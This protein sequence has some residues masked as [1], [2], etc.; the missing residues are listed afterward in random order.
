MVSSIT[1][2]LASSFTFMHLH[3]YCKYLNRLNFMYFIEM[4]IRCIYPFLYLARYWILRI[5]CKYSSLWTSEHEEILTVCIWSVW[6][7]L[8]LG[9]LPLVNRFV[10]VVEG[11]L[12]Y[13]KAI[14]RKKCSIYLAS[15]I[16]E[17][18]DYFIS[19]FMYNL[20]LFITKCRGLY[21]RHWDKKHKQLYQVIIWY[22]KVDI[23]IR[24]FR[25]IIMWWDNIL[26][27]ICCENL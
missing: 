2:L 3:F 14:R 10:S 4:Q 15:S 16:K 5:I 8:T 6:G 13:F 7:I 22:Y 26:E 18:I 24:C 23:Y 19:L 21:V 17:N 12:R 11:P 20:F 27:K 1:T 9:H 25:L